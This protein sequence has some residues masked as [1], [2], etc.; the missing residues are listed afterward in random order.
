MIDAYHIM[1]FA[2]I[3]IPMICVFMWICSAKLK[4]SLRRISSDDMVE[5]KLQRMVPGLQVCVQQWSSILEAIRDK[6]SQREI[7]TIAEE[8]AN[9]IRMTTRV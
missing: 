2:V 6:K 1:I 9:N 8:L 4:V 3:T 7:D 5:L